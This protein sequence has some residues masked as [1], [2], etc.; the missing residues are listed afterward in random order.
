M[1][2][3]KRAPHAFLA[4]LALCSTA[5]AFAATG[6]I[7]DVPE[8]R[9][10]AA[11][12]VLERVRAAKVDPAVAFAK[13][14]RATPQ[15]PVPAAVACASRTWQ[16]LHAVASKKPSRLSPAGRRALSGP[17]GSG[18]KGA[19]GALASPPYTGPS[20]DFRPVQPVRTPPLRNVHPLPPPRR[21]ED[22]DEG[23][24]E[25][26]RPVPPT[27][28]GGPDTAEH[29]LTPG[30]AISAPTPTGLGFDGVGVGLAGF[31][32]SSNP[33][34]VNGR[35][36]ATQFVQWN[37][38]SFAVFSK[39]TGA[40]LYGPAAGNTLFQSIGGACATHNDGD[41]VVAYD[42]LAGRWILSQFVVSASPSFS[43]QC[44]AVSV[45]GDATGSYYLYDFVTDA[46]NFVDYPHIGVWP[47]GYYMTSHVFNAAGTAQV[48]ARVSVFERQKMIL[49]QA[50]RMVQADLSKKSN[51]FQYGFLPADLDSITPP[52]A[53][54]A[55]FVLGPDPAFS[56][57]TDSTRVAV[58]WGAT[59]AITLTEATISVGISTPPCVNN[60][61]AQEN[62]DCVPQPSPAVGAD[63]LD[64]LAFHYMYRL[65]YRNF[66]GSPI[67]ESLVVAAPQA[68]SASTPGHGA[69]RWFE[70][71]NAGSSTTT[72]TSFQASTYDPDTA[73]RWMPSA[74]MDKDHNIALGYS[75]SSTSVIPGIYMTG[76]LG[77][78][79]INT[80]GAETTVMAGLGVQTTGAGNRWGDYSAMTLDPI[81]QCTFWYTNEYLKT[82][83]A[84]N[85]STRIASFKFP[86]CTS[87]AA[88]GTVS[89]T[90]TSCLTGAPLSGVV[91]TLSNG[92][93]GATDASGNYSIPVPAGSYTATA[94]DA[95]RNCATSSPASVAVAVASGGASTQNFCMTGTSNLQSNGVTLDDAT[96]GNNNGIINSNECVN[97][98]VA[99]RNNGCANESGIT[100][101]LT[102]A[103]AGVTVTQAGSSYSNLVIDAAGTNATPFK[104]QTSNS[105]VCGTAISLTL[106]LTYAGG[107]KSIG[108]SLPTC[109]GG[110]SQSIPTSAITLADSSQ[111]DRLGRD[112]LASPCAGKGCPGAINTAGS[113]NYKTFNFSNNGGGPACFTVQINA[114][115]GSADIQSAAYLT[116]YAPPTAQGDAAG[117]LCLRYLGDTGVVGLGTTVP[118]ASYSFEVPAS[119]NFVVVVNTSTGSTTCSQFS[120]LVSGFFNFTPG[121]GACPACTPP[122]TPAAGNGGPYCAGA[123][124]ALSTP[125]VAGATYAWTG[126]NGF[127]SALQNPT[128]ANATTAD[129][130]TYS[131]TVTVAGCTSAAGTTNVAVNAVPA[132]PAASNGGPYCTGA[133]IALS[134]PT[135]AGATY[136]W[137]G[138]SGFTS[139]QQNPTNATQAGTYFVTVTVNGCTSAAGSTNVVVNAIPATPTASNGGPYCTGAPIALS[140]PTVAG[141]TY[142]WTGPNG[143]TS[144]QQNPSNATEAGT[145]FV[146]VTVNGCTSAAGSTTV[147]VNPVPATPTASNGGPYCTG[148]PIALSTPTVADAT[149]AWTGPSGFTSSQQNPSNAT[150]AGTYFVT[151]TVNGCTSAAGST[152]VIVNAIPATPTAS[153]GGPYCTGAPI[154]LSTPTVAGATYAWTGPNGFTSS[155]QNPSNATEA[156]T[157]FVT[158]T[159]NGCTSSAGSTTV[160]VNPVP[161]TPT[162][163]N[164]GPYCAGAPIALS[165][166]TVA[167][168]T[169]AWTGPNGFTSTQQNPSNATEAGTYFVTVTV[170]GCTSAAGST[171]V[172]VNPV[173]A[174]PTASNGGPYCTGAPIA[175]STPTVAG[176]TY[177]WTGPNGFTSSQQNPA[178]ATE[179]GTYFVTVTVN[180]CTSAA[181]STTV[182]VNPVPATP[183]ASNGGPYC[184][185]AP[186]ALSTPTVAGATYAWTGPN[187]FTSAQQNPSNATDAGTYFV[188]VTVNGCTSAAGSTTVIVNPVPATPTASNGGPYCT[189]AQIALSTPTVAGAT[190][191][192]TGPNGFTSA[193]QNPSNATEA[194]TYFVTVTVNGCTSAAGSTS[195]VVNATP[196]TPTASNGGPYCT[197]AP[198]AL[199]TPTVAG[200]TYAWTGPSGFI[201]AQQNPSNATE[202]GTYF[203]TVTVN[204]CTSAAGSTT[205][206]VNPVPATPTASNGGPYCTGAPIALSTPTVAGATYAWTGPSGFTSAQ[207]NPSN[208]SE[209][210]TYFVTVTVNG[211]TSAA[212]ST[213]VV[214]NA[215]P[216]TPTASNGGPYC[217]GAPIALSTPTVAG[218]TYAWTGPSGFTSSQ[219]N[220]ANATQ[221]GTYFV[222]VTV[223]G[224]TSA[225]GSTTVIVSPVP[226]TPTASNGGPYCTGAPIALSTSTVAGATYAWTGPN[227]FTSAQQNPSNA[228]EAGT[229]FVTVTVNGCTSAAGSTN[230][231]VNA[232]PA[233]PTAS[234]GGPY[235]TGAPIALSTPTVAGATYAW[236]GPSGFTSS[237]QNPANATEAGTYFVTVTVNGCTSAAGSTSVVVNATP[238]TPTASN[239]GPYCTGAPIALSTPTVAG[240]TY[241]WTG[242]N[243]FTSAQQNPSNAT[244]AGTYFVTVTVNGCTSAAGSTSV[245]VNATPAT[246]TAS[247]GGPYCTGAPIALSTP[248]LAGATYAWTGPNGFTSAQQNPSNAT[249]AGTYF[250]TVTV[251]GCTS[252]A[253]STTVTVNAKPATPTITP[254]GPTTFCTGGSV[255]L[256]SS[257]AGGNQWSL[258]G[259]PIG[260]ATS[261]QYLASVAGDYTVIVTTGGCSST[262]S[263][264]TTVTINAIP[265][266]T[267]TA[268]AGVVSGSTG[269]AASVANAGVGATYAWSAT[270]G[271]ISGGNNTPNV[272]FTAGAAGTLTLQVTV[273]ANGC[274]DTKSANV[275]VTAA[276]APVTITSVV[277]SAGKSSGGKDVTINGTGFQS[278]ATVAFGGSAATS[279]V[280]VN[281]TRITA[282]T[283]A[284]AP[285]AIAVTVTN[286][287]T[288]TAT[289]NDGYTFVS[290]QF[291]ANGDN[292]IDPSDIF[293]LINYLFLSGP[294]PAGAAG[295]LSGDANGDDLVDPADI[296]YLINHLFMSG[297]TPASAPSQ[298]SA[299]SVAV[300]ISGAVTLGEPVRRGSRYV[301]P[302][303]VSMAPGSAAA[304]AL[305][306][307][308]TFRGTVT[309]AA[310]HHLGTAQPSFEISHRSPNALAY[311]LAFDQ[312]HGMSGTVAEIEIDLRDGA[313][314]SVDVD[315]VLTL[316][317]NQSGTSKA[318]VAIGTLRIGGTAIEAGRPRPPKKNL[319]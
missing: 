96:H 266:A 31:T 172:I 213:T 174:T 1:I 231:V 289:L 2:S 112:G 237:Q 157:Y 83:G 303:N 177:A 51:R 176:A 113:R 282:K 199:S 101:T 292:V 90:V 299:Q 119:S 139:A 295:M 285:G 145:Y 14:H 163:S 203:V 167:G 276:A 34:D 296:F 75:K 108:L 277:P 240:A 261:Q 175:L 147:I 87:A 259:S 120:G 110:A 126:P 160:I 239:G 13:E 41:P 57:R 37:N 53:G 38:T 121:P 69:V 288:G 194:G 47:D 144:S 263:A 70:F 306:L 72:P 279:V 100:A 50:A 307:R 302:V 29:Q 278:G 62:R 210:G 256:S 284:H 211:C 132:T 247:N 118:S 269:N 309:G 89:G 146:T 63:Y 274:S 135:V 36:G 76:R 154:A 250:V 84:F 18:W 195:V 131:V 271:T 17:L 103:T 234:N 130:G 319:D 44:V 252:A 91:V 138:P 9:G 208:A 222:T 170:N 134:T 124:I 58:T 223:N 218:A 251:N 30:L 21:G 224:C 94:A 4:V 291:D 159:V 23:H 255:M 168:A 310:I 149:Y 114:S 314:L 204:G 28:S 220:P 6:R 233:T 156:G 226:A 257:S 228:T 109:A 67:Q 153:N 268:P 106:N 48:A 315:P 196:A 316:L 8:C 173:P 68:G 60:T 155:Q 143:F 152:N 232:I 238:A 35:V 98:N 180:G 15:T 217:T 86:S 198:I 249:D 20:Q 78:D 142:A 93:A 293:Y 193:Q 166:P 305:S 300:P 80:M 294:P 262:A 137:T 26:I 219:Q 215:T 92:F 235:C 16:A 236:T 260:G 85:W 227:G 33:P 66:G 221:A 207:Q 245:V 241:G 133:P 206:I 248:T 117:N 43:H 140:T 280:V 281:A 56:N 49:G 25:P 150:Q 192:W 272:T 129:A 290:V 169:Y 148:A 298:V 158:V 59:P 22:R 297:P 11:K 191:A 5:S 246:P 19:P 27:E 230:V 10:V 73:Y 99:V 214:V 161:A 200:A 190:Y 187:G 311:L 253:G 275:N 39:T 308:L 105:F 12:E 188:T 3:M 40:L 317:S 225:A 178:N 82:N 182:I 79:T 165:T 267:I 136:A 55:S 74:A 179:A 189:G 229:Y 318:T 107:S 287:D 65:A 164:G 216:A 270:N 123:T 197:G 242:P 141:A 162:A 97:L 125:T 313:T 283:P 24:P 7:P 183:T 77:T 52:P 202:A 254:G 116:S 209:A 45:T 181:G 127:T 32:P 201:S 115:C 184:I 81:D 88:W 111:P 151:V 186:I 265:N 64:N 273:T 264:A 46:T 95:D 61:A 171:T 258:N 102:T 244:D 104:I 128:R 71:R 54:E 286:P 205:V 42:I 243:G 122:A 185:G 312:A 212:G 301:I 304:Q